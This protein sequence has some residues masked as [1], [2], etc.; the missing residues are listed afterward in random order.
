MQNSLECLPNL[1]LAV[2]PYS[3]KLFVTLLLSLLLSYEDT[4]SR[5]A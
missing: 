5:T 4:N 3:L 1:L 2:D